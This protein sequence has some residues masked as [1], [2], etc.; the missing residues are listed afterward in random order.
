MPLDI[1]AAVKHLKENAEPGPIGKCATYVR[2]ALQAGGLDMSSRP[3]SAKSLWSF[4]ETLGLEKRRPEKFST[5]ERRHSSH[6]AL[7]GRECAWPCC[8]V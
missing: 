7:H 5:S 3:I 4:L 6:S 8:H 1:D 2:L